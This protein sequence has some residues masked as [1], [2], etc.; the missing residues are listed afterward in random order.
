MLYEDFRGEWERGLRHHEKRQKW[1][2][3][4]FYFHVNLKEG[5]LAFILME[6]SVGLSCSLV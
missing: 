5:M 3:Q 1:H 2:F 4:G 6:Y